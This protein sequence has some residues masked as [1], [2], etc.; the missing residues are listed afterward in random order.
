M[1][2]STAAQGSLWLSEF[3]RVRLRLAGGC[4]F[5]AGGIDRPL[6]I[7]KEGVATVIPHQNW[8]GQFA[9]GTYTIGQVSDCTGQTTGCTAI[10]WPRLPH[11]RLARAQRRRSRHPHLVRRRGE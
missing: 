6:V 1:W 5:H 8:R 3:T 4:Y 11:H 7:R 10:D 2:S 9:R